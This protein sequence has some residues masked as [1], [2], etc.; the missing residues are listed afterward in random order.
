MALA[1]LL[2]GLAAVLAEGHASGT[3]TLSQTNMA[4]RVMNIAQVSVVDILQPLSKAVSAPRNIS[5]AE[6]LMI[7]REYDYSRI[8]LL[9]QA[10][11]VSG[12]VD[13]FDVLADEK[14]LDPEYLMTPPELI[15]AATNIRE[16]LLTMQ[17]TRAV[18]AIA[19]D[20]AGKHLG[21]VTVKDIVEE[22]VGD[23]EEW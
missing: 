6:F 10:G 9:D 1:A 22:I 11:Q 15:P 8:P 20:Q 3:L 23:L 12:V 19:T 13:V 2:G 7:V 21:I 14:E 16:A 17:R 4:E 18:F 5:R